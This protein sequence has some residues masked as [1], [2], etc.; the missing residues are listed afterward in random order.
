LVLVEV[1]G[2]T[3]VHIT[4]S[5]TLREPSVDIEDA[6]AHETSALDIALAAGCGGVINRDAVCGVLTECLQDVSSAILAM[7][8]LFALL[9]GFLF[10]FVTVLGFKIDQCY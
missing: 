1:L 10:V 6:L 5:H 9:L 8:Y 4:W 3:G 7:L 2:G